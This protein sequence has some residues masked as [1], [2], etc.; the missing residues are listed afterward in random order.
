MKMK[1]YQSR[2]KA[3]FQEHKRRYEPI[4]RRWIL[5]LLAPAGLSNG[6]IS[7][8]GRVRDDDVAEFIGLQELDERDLHREEKIRRIEKQW[9]KDEDQ[10]DVD[11][12]DGA[13]E[14]NIWQIKE[15]L[16]LGEI[17]CEILHFLVLLN[18]SSVLGDAADLAGEM[19]TDESINLLA[20]V[21]DYPVSKVRN[22]LR[23]GATLQ[24]SGLI[25]ID[26]RTYQLKNKIELL[27]GLQNQ[28][29]SRQDS[30]MDMVN[31]LILPAKKVSLTDS[32][33]N[34][35]AV[36]RDRIRTYLSYALNKQLAGVNI[37]IH[38]EPG[39]GKTEMV[40][41][42][43]NGLGG[44]NLYELSTVDE[45]DDA[46]S[47]NERFKAYRLSQKLLAS[48]RG[49][50]ILFD[51]IE[52]VFPSDPF[53]ALFGGGRGRGDGKQKGWI[54]EMLETNPVPAFWVSNAIQQMDPAYLRRFDLVVE[55]PPMTH[56][57]RSEMLNKVLNDLPLS[58]PWIDRM[59]HHNH[60]HPG[61]IQRAH[62]VVSC[63]MAEEEEGAIVEQEME[64]LIGETQVAM[65]NPKKPQYSGSITTPYSLEFLN[66]DV[67]LKR[68]TQGLA[69]T[70][71][72]R[73]CLYGRPG[74]GKSAYANEVAKVLG[75]PLISRKGSD[76]LGMYVGQTE[77]Q[78]ASM[79]Q[80]AEEEN[81][82]LLLDEGDS[83]LGDRTAANH[84]WEVT[85]V[86]ELLTQME[87]FEGIFIISTNLMENLDAAS[88]RRFDF[89][90]KFDYMRPEQSWSMFKAVAKSEGV[91]KGLRSTKI[92]EG[93]KRLENL[94]PG[95]FATVVRRSRVLG[96]LV[97]GVD[98]LQQLVEECESKPGFN[99]RRIGFV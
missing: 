94:T 82:V 20:A 67:D 69:G 98:L 39:V 63:L 62:K 87:S 55:I 14:K 34:H 50:V 88:L 57:A 78:I 58:K 44:S 24:H 35:V 53:A 18:E 46:M 76:L 7:S 45:D 93:V 49:A 96:G 16:G 33:F 64:T 60:L 75:R 15:S 86:N 61:Q 5:R 52:D 54:N 8:H 47:G 51:E 99:K 30:V 79:F 23:R 89:K 6:L 9:K 68:L 4:I 97:G 83:F 27:D 11:I 59:A 40:R 1:K 21:L 29:F 80:Q 42:L 32:D 90:V 48:K 72:A 10:G 37:L 26:K 2:N 13:L 25:Q 95:D 91:K 56:S 81:A 3:A 66:S 73:I 41:T 71:S 77:Q 19:N 65:G 38:G 74:T 28:L 43:V 12:K 92:E 84:S 70:P 85:Q 31:Y 36:K 22:V 17:E